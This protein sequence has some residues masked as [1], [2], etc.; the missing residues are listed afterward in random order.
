VNNFATVVTVNKFRRITY[1]TLKLSADDTALFSQFLKAHAAPEFKPDMDLLRHWM[2]QLGE[3]IGA[4][5]DY[6][7][8]EGAAHAIPPPLE[9]TRKGC[10]LRL[11]CLRMSPRVVILFNG[12][13]KTKN[14]AQDC[15]IVA[16]HFEQANR[17]ALLLWKAY[18]EGI[19]QLDDRDDLIIPHDFKLEL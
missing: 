7:R 1:Y 18:D 4:S 2:R 19:L 5:T 8:P 16:P 3:T 12:G 17:L 13:V 15:P 11:Y 14:K 10:R 9:I 6:L